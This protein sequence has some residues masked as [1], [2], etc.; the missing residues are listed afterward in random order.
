MWKRTVSAEFPHQ[1]IRRYYCI[2]CSIIKKH[3]MNSDIFRPFGRPVYRFGCPCLDP[4]PFFKGGGGKFWLPEKIKI[5]NI[6]KG[7][8]KYGAGVSLL[9]RGARHFSYLI[10][11]RFIIF[12]FRNYPCPLQNCVMHL[13]KNDFFLSP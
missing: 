7:G 12:K 13:K 10:F 9:K 8:W 5:W 2:L 1:E 3:V 6:K 4:P 11:S